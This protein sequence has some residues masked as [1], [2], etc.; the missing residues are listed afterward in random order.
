MEHSVLFDI[1]R[2]TTPYKHLEWK[3]HISRGQPARSATAPPHKQEAGSMDS[4][5]YTAKHE[6]SAEIAE[7]N[8]QTQPHPKFTKYR[9]RVPFE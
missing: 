6:C 4:P 3:F 8:P 7:A 2:T 5:T 1:L 9:L